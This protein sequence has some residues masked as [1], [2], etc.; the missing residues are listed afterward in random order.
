MTRPL[1]GWVDL[2]GEYSV[3]GARDREPA[4]VRV[5]GF[6]LLSSGQSIC[7]SLIRGWGAGRGGKASP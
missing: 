3:G 7:K 2:V 1:G 5:R 6:I 4:R